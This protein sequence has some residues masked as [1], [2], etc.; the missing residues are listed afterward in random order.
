MPPIVIDGKE[1]DFDALPDNAKQ[2]INTIR[3]IDAE[4]ARLQNLITVQKTART[5]YMNLVQQALTQA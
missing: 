2:C 4:V 1:Y 5:V 3:F